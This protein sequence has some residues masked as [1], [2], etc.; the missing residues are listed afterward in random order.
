M[1]Q[2]PV[3]LSTDDN[4]ALYVA[5]TIQSLAEVTESDQELIIFILY[6]KLNEKT[7]SMFCQLQNNRIK[8]VPQRIDGSI[9]ARTYESDYFTTAM[10]YRLAIPELFP[11]Y[12]KIL[13]IDCDIIL[14]QNIA[15][16]FEIDLSGYV[17]G[18]IY[19]YVDNALRKYLDSI[20]YK[21]EKYFT[22]HFDENGRAKQ[23]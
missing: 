20:E 4:Y 1:K 7:L 13:Y 22:Y 12:E 18:A 2:Y 10:Y 8:V 23:L 5:V 9:F 6:E 14:K 17:M 19:E 3:V 15:T 16:L 11:Q 21:S